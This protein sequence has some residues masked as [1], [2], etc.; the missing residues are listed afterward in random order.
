M[1]SNGRLVN[2]RPTSP[3][4]DYILGSESLKV[5]QKPE[6]LGVWLQSDL[7]FTTHINDKVNKANRQL[8][9]I[10]RALYSAPESAKLLA[11]TSLCRPHVEYAAAVWDPH[12]EYL[13]QDVEKIQHKAVRFIAK[14]KGRESVTAARERLLIDTLATRRCNIRRNLLLRLLSNEQYHNVLVDDY[15]ELLSNNTD[16]TPATRAMTRGDPRTIY[17]KIPAYYNSFLPKTVREMKKH[18]SL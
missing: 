3:N 17:A 12:L 4:F 7:K 8:G 13:I 14:L 1:L 18:V 11:Y 9:L 10:K 2:Q 6:Y 5:V 16:N 15:D